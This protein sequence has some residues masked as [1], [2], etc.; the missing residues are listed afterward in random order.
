MKISIWIPKTK[1]PVWIQDF[2]NGE[3]N[4]AGNIKSKSTRE[5]V[6]DGLYVAQRVAKPGIGLCIEGKD[7]E[8]E[9]YDGKIFKY[10]CGREF[11]KPETQS[12][13]T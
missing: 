7:F 9:N 12:D 2:I 8:A 5:S 3:I 10:H 4:Q 13:Y 6:A 1:N 11:I